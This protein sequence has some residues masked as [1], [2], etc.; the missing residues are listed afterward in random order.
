MTANDDKVK[1]AETEENLDHGGFTMQEICFAL[2]N[3]TLDK[4]RY[5]RLHKC[6][7]LLL[8]WTMGLW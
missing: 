7:N 4:K 6:F 2:G 8:D 3:G 1:E 5:D